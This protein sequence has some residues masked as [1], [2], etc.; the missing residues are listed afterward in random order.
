MYWTTKRMGIENIINYIL[1]S[2]RIA[3]SGQPDE[4]QFK[5]IAEANYKVVINLAMSN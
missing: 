4:H 5:Y 2:D 1:V 3:S